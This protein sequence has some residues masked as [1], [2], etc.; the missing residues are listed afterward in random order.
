MLDMGFIKDIRRI[1][2]LLPPRRQNL[3][4]SAT[5]SDDVRD[6]A[7]TFLH[8][9]AQVQVARR[10]APIELVRQVVYPV[11]R[12]RKRELLS[13]LIRSGRIDRGARVHPH[14]ARRQPPR[15]AARETTASTPSRST[16]TSPRAS[17]SA[18][19][20][21]S[22]RAAPPS[23]SRPRSRP[24]AS[25][26][27]GCR[28][29]STSSCRRCPRTTSTASVG[30]VEPGWRATRSRSSAS[31]RPTCSRISSASS[32]GRSR[33][34]RRR[35]RARSAPSRRAHPRAGSGRAIERG[36]APIRTTKKSG[37]TSRSPGWPAA[38]RRACAPPGH[39]ARRR[40]SP[41]RIAS[42]SPAR[43]GATQLRRAAR[44]ALREVDQARLRLRAAR[45][46]AAAT[47]LQG[48]SRARFGPP[49]RDGNVQTRSLGSHHG[50]QGRLVHLR[51]TRRDVM[52]S[53][54]T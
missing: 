22:R 9:P 16:A 32:A 29:S 28:M 47:R 26:S 23:S 5:F 13:Y 54:S 3:L 2:A 7:A 21:T 17:A 46:S 45:S 49:P 4:F 12:S 51:A 6:L 24:A 33:G 19:S 35:L 48:F 40:A 31:T 43:G 27:T 18:P 8:D 11:D 30:P 38:A 15:R 10:N 50:D 36:S 25:T 34:R 42:G 41:R 44:R 53:F 37:A 52:R 39:V 1:I 14:E 20:T